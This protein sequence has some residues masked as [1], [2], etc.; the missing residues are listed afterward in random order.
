MPSVPA[1]KNRD[2]DVVSLEPLPRELVVAPEDQELHLVLIR[3]RSVDQLG[4]LHLRSA[5][6]KARDDVKDPSAPIGRRTGRRGRT[7]HDASSSARTS[8]CRSAP[9]ARQTC[10]SAR[11]AQ[12]R[13][14]RI[15]GFLHSWQHGHPLRRSASASQ[16]RF[17]CTSGS[18]IICGSRCVRTLRIAAVAASSVTC[19]TH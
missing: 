19:G 4:E 12:T 13:A 6:T 3:G 18:S 16:Y 8:A 17:V 15:P 2:L 1:L 10:A 7:K 11:T 5:N 14:G 9:T